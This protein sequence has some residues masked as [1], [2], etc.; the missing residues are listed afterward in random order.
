MLRL[1]QAQDETP[2]FLS[3]IPLALQPGATGLA[4]RQASAIEDLRTVAAARLLLD[5]FPHIKSYWIMLG[6]ETASVALNFG[7]SD[8][9]GTI[10][11][12][13]IAHYA[14]AKSAVGLAREKLVE[15][16]RE[17]GKR[18]VER[19]ALYHVMRAYD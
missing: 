2:G 13:R 6:E 10:G 17:A 3:F 4:E 8:L 18:P 19:D 11:E 1:R 14:Q 12:E 9:D 7:A 5:N 15:M 16:I